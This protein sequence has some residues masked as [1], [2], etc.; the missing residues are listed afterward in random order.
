MGERG[1]KKTLSI[2]RKRKHT[3]TQ[4]YTNTK[5]TAI[6]KNILI[7]IKTSSPPRYFIVQ[8]RVDDYKPCQSEL[9]SVPS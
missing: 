5:K 1:K 2:K 9:L 4:P 3:H 6:T 7:K 8:A